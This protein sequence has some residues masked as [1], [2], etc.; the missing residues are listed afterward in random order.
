V[1]LGA[2]KHGEEKQRDN[3][4]TTKIVELLTLNDE[5]ARQKDPSREMQQEISCYLLKTEGKLP[6]ASPSL[7][8]SFLRTSS[9]F[10]G[11]TPLPLAVKLISFLTSPSSMSFFRQKHPQ[12]IIGMADEV[13]ATIINM[14]NHE[15]GED[16]LDLDL[17]LDLGG[18]E[19]VKEELQGSL[20]RLVKSASKEKVVVPNMTTHS[21]WNPR[22]RLVTNMLES[23]EIFS[24]D[25]YE[26]AVLKCCFSI[27]RKVIDTAESSV[28]THIP[29][30]FVP[31]VFLHV[32][33]SCGSSALSSSLVELIKKSIDAQNDCSVSSSLSIQH[34]LLQPYNKIPSM[35]T[36]VVDSLTKRI[37]SNMALAKVIR[38]PRDFLIALKIYSRLPPSQVKEDFRKGVIVRGLDV[39]DYGL[40]SST[41]IL[42]QSLNYL[43]SLMAEEI[44]L[45]SKLRCCMLS[46]YNLLTD[47]EVGMVKL[48]DRDVV[49]I[50]F[51]TEKE[52][53]GDGDGD[54]DRDRDRDG[55]GVREGEDGD[56]VVDSASSKIRILFYSKH[57]IPQIFSLLASNNVDKTQ[58]MKLLVG[59]T[60]VD[61]SEFRF[62]VGGVVDEILI[63]LA[64]QQRLDDNNGGSDAG[65]S[66]GRC[67]LLLRTLRSLSTLRKSSER[68]KLSRNE[69]SRNLA[70]EFLHCYTQTEEAI[71]ASARVRMMCIFLEATDSSVSGSFQ[72]LKRIE[73]SLTG[74]D[75]TSLE[76]EFTPATRDVT[77]I[78]HNLGR[79]RVG[80]EDREER[81]NAIGAWSRLAVGGKEN[82]PR[83]LQHLS[84][85]QCTA[86]MNAVTT[87]RLQTVAVDVFPKILQRLEETEIVSAQSAANMLFAC[88]EMG[89]CETQAKVLMQRFLQKVVKK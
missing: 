39:V 2:G 22:G 72:V 44:G 87:H 54:G 69:L 81:K 20:L 40:S 49:R 86:I 15:E 46:L 41:A 29:L 34:S 45:R 88:E 23:V 60:E 3:E 43:R 84:S 67:F 5:K 53:H 28:D 76:Q 1:R 11:I 58:L 51:G 32:A 79:M 21:T 59:L 35:E 65:E 64:H 57:I 27:V 62:S 68:G 31:P 75:C 80:S 7:Y 61:D 33:R 24:E 16:N 55:D 25:T 70:M 38:H 6:P 77:T 12:G 71:K 73:S 17:D 14:K 30:N 63:G 18:G 37:V 9:T 56:G 48:S 74:S 83:L 10:S 8:L 19:G 82:G 4:T 50:V 26:E 66:I 85:S 89:V 47:M 78:I 42:V 36:E 52:T 13:Y